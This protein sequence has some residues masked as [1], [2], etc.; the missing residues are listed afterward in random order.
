MPEPV[1]ERGEG[2]EGHDQHELVDGHHQHRRRI[3]DAEIAGDGRQRHRRDGA[4][5]DDQAVPKE[6]ATMA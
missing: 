5:D 2:Q 3:V 6:M 1:A 4:V